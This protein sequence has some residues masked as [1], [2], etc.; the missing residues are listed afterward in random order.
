MNKIYSEQI[1]S[2]I[3]KYL[4]AEVIPA[5]SDTFTKLLL[6]TT[7][8]S[9]EVN[10]QAYSKAM[11]SFI[12]QPFVSDLLRVENRAFEIESIIDALR[13]AVNEC[14]ELVIKIPPVK[15]ISPEEKTLRFKADDISTLKQYLTNETCEVLE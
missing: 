14:G 1:I 15:F 5:V 12:Q 9:S 10:G 3:M 4:N 2:G 6:K 8:I 11:D 7:V 13:Q